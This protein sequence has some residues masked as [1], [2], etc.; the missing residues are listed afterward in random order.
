MDILLDTHTFIWYIEG[1]PKLT[2]KAR[3]AIEMSADKV[4][5]SIIS[6]WEIAIKT[7]KNQLTLQN[8]FDDLLDVLNSLQIE[9]LSITFADTQIYK[10]LPLHHGDPFDRMIIAQAISNN[11]I[12]VGCDQSF[13]NYPIQILWK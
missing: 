9:I 10:N 6:L 4:Y 8:Q 11:L 13:N 12:V 7:G 3:E 5:L 1:N 2:E